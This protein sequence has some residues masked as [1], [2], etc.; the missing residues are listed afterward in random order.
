MELL[1]LAGNMSK[2]LRLFV[3]SPELLQW[4]RGCPLPLGASPQAI[5]ELHHREYSAGDT[6]GCSAVPTGWA[7]AW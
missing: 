5:T 4:Q 1:R 3:P 6:V 7:S 2:T